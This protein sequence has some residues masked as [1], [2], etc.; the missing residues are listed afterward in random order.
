MVK[1]SDDSRI[2]G[3]NLRKVRL[4]KG[5]MQI[6]VAVATDFNRSYISRL[7]TGKARITYLVFCRLIQGLEIT[8]N[9]LIA[10]L[11]R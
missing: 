9:E 4:K 3:L 7:E 1:H 5:L 6:D 10:N 11:R 8:P 2:I